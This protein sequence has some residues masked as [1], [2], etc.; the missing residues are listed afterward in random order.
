[1]TNV[2]DTAVGATRN[3]PH[4]R[5][6]ILASSSV[7]P[8][9]RHHLRFGGKLSDAVAVPDLVPLRVSGTVRHDKTGPSWEYSVVVSVRNAKGEEVTRHVVGVGA[10]PPGDERTFTLAVEVFTGR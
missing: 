5:A 6:Q 4:C 3:C 8:A 1:M 2:R 10:L 9:C 7:C